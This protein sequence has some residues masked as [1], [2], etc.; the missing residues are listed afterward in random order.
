M[1]AILE[2]VLPVF[3]L[4]LLGWSAA[5]FHYLS[6]GTGQVLAQFAFKVAMP[7]LLFRTTLNL[8]P[9]N[10][11]PV[12][13]A[14]AY[15]GV[16]LVVWVLASLATRFL[17][18]RPAEDTAAIAMGVCFG[19]TVMLG[20]PVALTAFGEAAAVP[21]ALIITIDSPLLWLLATLQMELFRRRDGGLRLDAIA[22][23]ARDVVFNPIVLPLILGTVGRQL[24]LTLPP[25]PDKLLALLAQAAVPTA[26]VA[27]GTTL[28]SFE[29]KG[30]RPTIGLILV[31]KLLVFPCLV[32]VAT[33]AVGLPPVWIAVA[34]LLAAMPVGANAFLFAARYERGVGSVSAAVA[35]STGLAVVSVSIVLFLLRGGA[36]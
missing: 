6:P 21:A 32:V 33:T 18:G 10:G 15:F 26:L 17:L 1:A 11:D 20:I 7:A 27:L 12:A 28:V 14:I 23:V 9:W 3:S 8:A 5:R 22:G 24:G 13:L 34:T 16:M 36:G 2:I 30:Q 4:I 31:L 29:I 25:I 35:V 19:N